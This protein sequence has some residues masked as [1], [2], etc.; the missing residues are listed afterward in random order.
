MVWLTRG[1]CVCVCVCVCVLCLRVQGF[2]QA[3]FG[4][5]SP[6]TSEIPPMPSPYDGFLQ[7]CSDCSDHSLSRA[8]V[9]GTLV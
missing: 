7:T 6:Q 4:G 1:L 2:I 3:P 8:I 9:T 5:T